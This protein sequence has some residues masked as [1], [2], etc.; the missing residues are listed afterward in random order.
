MALPCGLGELIP[1]YSNRKE[2]KN[3]RQQNGNTNTVQWKVRKAID[4]IWD[5]IIRGEG[6][7]RTQNLR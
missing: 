6:H 2:K 1:E 7:R 5:G 3:I 4:Q